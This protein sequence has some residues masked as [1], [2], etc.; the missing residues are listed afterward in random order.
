MHTAGDNYTPLSVPEGARKLLDINVFGVLNTFIPVI[1]PMRRRKYGQL[2][3]VCSLGSFA[4]TM[5]SPA[6]HG[7]KSCV[8][9][10]G[11][12]LRPLLA[13]DGIGVTVLCPGFVK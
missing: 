11:E 8:R 10:F 12:G 5:V 3:I 2:V 13:K 7:S 6:Y 1:E 4:P 9:L